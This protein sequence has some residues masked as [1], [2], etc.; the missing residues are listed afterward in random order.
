MKRL[1]IAM[2]NFR[3]SITKDSFQQLDNGSVEEY[4]EDK[5]GKQVIRSKKLKGTWIKC[6]AEKINEYEHTNFKMLGKNG[7]INR[8]KK[9]SGARFF[10][11]T[12]NTLKLVVTLNINNFSSGHCNESRDCEVVYS[13]SITNELVDESAGFVII[14]VVKSGDHIHEDKKT[15]IRGTLLL[16]T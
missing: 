6:I 11:G 16:F 3:I 8:S 15:Q 2:N 13:L 12:G 4:T 5:N 7:R 14:D 10:S 9:H 1:I